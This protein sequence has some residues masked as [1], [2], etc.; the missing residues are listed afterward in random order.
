MTK[1]RPKILYI[2]DDPKLIDLVTHILR[3]GDYQVIGA[4]RGEEG[5]AAA[6]DHN[7]DLILLDLMLPDIDGWAVYRQLKGNSQTQFI[8]VIIITAKTQ[9]ID[10]VLGLNVAGVDAYINKPFFPQDLLDSV[11]N[12]LATGTTT[13]SSTE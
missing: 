8:P 3:R 6:Q 13:S 2:D 12:I 11:Q 9:P 1:S 5:I 10:R 4:E 7:P